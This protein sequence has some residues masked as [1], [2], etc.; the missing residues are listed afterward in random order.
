MNFR[1]IDKSGQLGAAEEDGSKILE[2]PNKK[3][4]CQLSMLERRMAQGT[5]NQMQLIEDSIRHA[6][7]AILLNVEDRNSWYNLGN[8]YL[9]Y[10]DV[11]PLYL[12]KFIT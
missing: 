4:L 1:Y 11:A 8:A 2:R 10:N 9:K 7:E 5:E 3:I 12:N 6:K